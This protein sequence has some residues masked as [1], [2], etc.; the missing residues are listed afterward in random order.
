MVV[1]QQTQKSNILSVNPPPP[2][3]PL[4]KLIFKDLLHTSPSLH[5]PWNSSSRIF[6]IPLYLF[7][8]LE[9][10]LQGSSTYL[11]I[12]SHPLKLIVKDLLHISLSLHIPW[13]SSSRIFYIS[14]Y[15]FTSLETHLQG[16]ST[17]LSISSHPLK[18]IF[19]DLLHTSLSL[20]I[21]WNSSSRIFY[22]PLYLFTS[23]ETHLQGSS[24]YLSISSHPLKLIFK[25]LLHISLSLHIT[26]VQ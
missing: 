8:S 12:S 5:I 25:D 23:L 16:S 14:L 2:P 1:N 17:Y 6:Y 26:C 18:L 3:P 20:H 24:T 10:H 13:N 7:T 4:L 15:L 19:K 11:S 22:I 9:T 21:P